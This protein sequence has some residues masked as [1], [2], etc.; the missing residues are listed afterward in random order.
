[1]ATPQRSLSQET[2]WT[3]I[4]IEFAAAFDQVRKLIFSVEADLANNAAA[5]APPYG[6]ETFRTLVLNIVRS[7]GDELKLE[8]TQTNRYTSGQAAYQLPASYFLS[9]QIAG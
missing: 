4:V 5:T 2:S 6:G 9:G 3:C 7:L 8:S 1:M